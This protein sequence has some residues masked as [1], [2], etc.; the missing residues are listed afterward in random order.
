MASVHRYWEAVENAITTTEAD[1]NQL[2][3]GRGV[4]G[5]GESPM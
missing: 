2:T 4:I 3:S 1:C 5:A